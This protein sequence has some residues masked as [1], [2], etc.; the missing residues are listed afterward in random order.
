MCFLL[1]SAI[2][3][4]RYT[5]KQQQLQESPKSWNNATMIR[6]SAP[7]LL[8][9]Q[10]DSTST[11]HSLSMPSIH[12][13]HTGQIKSHNHGYQHSIPNR[14]GT[15]VPV[16]LQH[17]YPSNIDVSRSRSPSCFSV[18]MGGGGNGNGEQ[19]NGWGVVQNPLSSAAVSSSW[20]VRACRFWLAPK[21]GTV[22]CLACLFIAWCLKTNVYLDLYYI[23]TNEGISRMYF[24][25]TL[26]KIIRRYQVF[27]KTEENN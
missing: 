25:I 14:T 7:P 2:V 15:P 27:F 18:K 24:R 4:Q 1:F 26:V 21:N 20:K 3:P 10:I 19:N 11:P 16:D 13:S 5:L 6:P 9:S 17:E 22:C 8:Q 12:N 23:L